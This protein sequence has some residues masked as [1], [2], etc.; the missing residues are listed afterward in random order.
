MLPDFLIIGAMK[1]GTS[2]LQV[3]L[4]AQSGI[5]MTTPK[6]PNYFS[7]DDVFARGQDWY[8]ELF[9]PARAGDLK[10]EASTHYTKLPT[11]PQTLA[12]MSAVLAAPRLIYVM[13]DPIKRAISHY[14]HEWSMG[15][16][17]DD[18]VVAFRTHPELLDYS[19]YGM[20]IEPYLNQYGRAAIHLVSFEQMTA[21]PQRV[22]SGIGQF[23]GR[24]DLIWDHGIEA[25]NVSAERV[26]RLPLHGLIVDSKL[27][28]VLRRTLVPKALRNRIRSARQMKTRPEL[29]ASLRNELAERLAGDQARLAALF[30][31][32]PA[33]IPPR[34][35]A[36]A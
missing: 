15:N 8:E 12:R 9:A 26:R 6:E 5:F 31:G 17:G 36:A 30:P 13:R 29:P 4:A 14:M 10:G 3:Q 22:L 35:E 23:L 32:D 28:T 18:P 7:D 2:T 20:Q 24:G 19:R 25:Q 33:L 11:Y 21:D 34:A 27:A 1:C 16:M